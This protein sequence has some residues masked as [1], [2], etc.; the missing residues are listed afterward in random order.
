MN[1]FVKNIMIIIIGTLYIVGM[2]VFYSW[3]L[4]T[5]LNLL[6]V[7]PFSWRY[8]VGAAMVMLALNYFFTQLRGSK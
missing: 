8:V 6:D 5:G 3:V 2:L 1:S 7:I 4:V